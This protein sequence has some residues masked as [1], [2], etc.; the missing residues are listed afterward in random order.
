MDCK[1]LHDRLNPQQQHHYAVVPAVK[2]ET[3]G[4]DDVSANCAINS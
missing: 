1:L 3:S 4:A 2:R